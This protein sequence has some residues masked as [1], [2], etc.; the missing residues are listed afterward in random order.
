MKLREN[1]RNKWTF[2]SEN[3]KVSSLTHN[4]AIAIKFDTPAFDSNISWL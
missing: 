3:Y 4:S 1:K 2:P